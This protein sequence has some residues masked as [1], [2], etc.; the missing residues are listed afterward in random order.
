MKRKS[1]STFP[2]GAR[3]RIEI[4]NTEGSC[5]WT[6]GYVPNKI[7]VEAADAV[8]DLYPPEDVP[9]AMASLLAWAGEAFPPPDGHEVG[10]L[11]NRYESG[12]DYISFHSD[13]EGGLDGNFVA[14]LSTG[15]DRS[16][17][18]KEKATKKTVAKLST[19]RHP[20][21]VMEG[22]SF[23]KE[24]IHGVPKKATIGPRTSFSIRW[25]KI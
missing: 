19:A 3:A 6:S 23:Q 16:F 25:H 5:L 22:P 15:A 8:K 2:A 11:V 18:V 17:V 14:T 13:D 24:Y 21:I 9:E 1:D 4:L 10:I 12:S 20:M 7:L